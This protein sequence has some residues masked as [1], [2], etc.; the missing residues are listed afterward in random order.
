MAFKSTET[1]KESKEDKPSITEIKEDVP[2][3]TLTNG[4]LKE[5]KNI[6]IA[7]A[8]DWKVKK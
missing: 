5:D 8:L 1:D 7:L 2:N 4:D 3:G 6:E